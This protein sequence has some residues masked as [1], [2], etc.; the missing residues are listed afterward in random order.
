LEQKAHPIFVQAPQISKRKEL[1]LE[2]LKIMG[3]TA[4]V[5][6]RNETTPCGFFLFYGM[7]ADLSRLLS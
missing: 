7:K 1:A 5:S 2:I 6:E 4:S 3:Y